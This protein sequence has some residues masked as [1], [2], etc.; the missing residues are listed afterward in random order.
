MAASACLAQP[1]GDEVILT[2]GYFPPPTK[3]ARLPPET[4][5][6]EF[7]ELLSNTSIKATNV[8]KVSL[9]I[10]YA[11]VLAK[12]ILDNVPLDDGDEGEEEE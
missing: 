11:I 1:F 4:T 5:D 10:S 6:E 3:F 8:T 12:T 7:E 2:F 9:P